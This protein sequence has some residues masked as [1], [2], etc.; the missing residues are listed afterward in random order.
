MD[1]LQENPMG[2]RDKKNKTRNSL[3]IIGVL[4]VILAIIAIVVYTYSQKLA[5]D[6]FKVYIDTMRIGKL[7]NYNVFEIRDGKV[8]VS[9]R[10]IAPNI[11]Y[12]VY[13]GGYKQ[14]SEDLTKC[15]VTNSKELVNFVSGEKSI[16]KYPQIGESES[17]KFDLDEEIFTKGNN[18]YISSEGLARAFNLSIAYTQET[19]TIEI[20]TL[21][22]ISTLYESRIATASLSKSGLEEALI[23][24]NQKAILRNL[25]VVQD[26]ET[27]L[28]GV[29]NTS[30]GTLTDVITSRYTS[31]QFIEG[32]DDFIV[33]SEDG[34]YG[35]IGNDG[36]TKINPQYDK[37]AEIDKDIGLYL[38]ESNGKQGVVNQNGK[39]IIYQD[40]DKLGL[41]GQIEDVN[42]TNRYLLYGNCIPVRRGGLWGIIDKNGNQ[43]LPIDYNGIGC[44]VAQDKNNTTGIVLIPEMEGI[45]IEK[46][47]KV[48]NETVKKYGIVSATGANLIN[49]VADSAYA[50]TIANKTTYYVSVQNEEIDIVNFWLE[51]KERVDKDYVGK[52]NTTSTND[53]ATNSTALNQTVTEPTVTPDTQVTTIPE[54][55]ED[56]SQTKV[57]VQGNPATTTV[58]EG[59]VAPIDYEAQR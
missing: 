33:I 48:G 54:I 22:Y 52:E 20:L 55:T 29:A 36:I 43:I 58:P 10:D 14:Y 45:V 25:L 7:E 1:L 49:I 11:G 44:T 15:Y 34:K 37:I 4:I 38:V 56:P 51:N 2:E 8:Y 53:V 35:I 18:L 30:T 13:N 6:S 40:Y 17:Q 9:I 24:S 42:V 47:Q 12:R 41:D 50:T 31:I 59:T 23:F 46:D 27:K 16:R 28:F 39:I 5:K 57:P 3:I 32:I 19:N 21:P 26:P